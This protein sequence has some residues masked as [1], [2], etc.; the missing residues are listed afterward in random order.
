[1]NE[2]IRSFLI[3]WTMVGAACSACLFLREALRRRSLA[4]V[5]VKSD[6]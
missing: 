4:S 5:R 2:G 3:M 6:R 1:V